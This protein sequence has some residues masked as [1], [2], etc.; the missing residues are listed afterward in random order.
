[1]NFKKPTQCLERMDF[2]GEKFTV[3]NQEGAEDRG[4][5]QLVA[6]GQAERG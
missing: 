6:A 3:A 1:M 5:V 2:E 4:K